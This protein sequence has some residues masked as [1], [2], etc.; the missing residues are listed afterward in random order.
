MR[1]LE[2]ILNAAGDGS[3]LTPG[4][5]RVIDPV[6]STA[7]RGYRNADHIH[8]SLFPPVDTSIRGG[9]RI[10]FGREDFRLLDTRRAP[11]A[12]YQEVQLGHVG[13]EFAVQTHGLMGKLPIEIE[14]DAMRV[15]GIDMGMR[16]VDG[17]Q[18][19]ISLR[20]E[21][22]AAQLATDSDNYNATHVLTLAGASQWSHKDSDP[23]ANIRKAINTTRQAIG[24][25]PKHVAL[26][27]SVFEALQAHK[28]ILK[29]VFGD[30]PQGQITPS[31]LAKLWNVDVVAVGDA[32]YLDDAGATAD[33]W[34]DNVVVH[35]AAV[36]P[37]TR[38]E[39]SWGLGYEID[40][41]VSVDMA[42]YDASCRSWK[43]PVNAEYADLIVGK[44][45]GY[46][47]KDVLA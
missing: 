9:T 45:A 35:Y 14:Q 42:W 5:A 13:K 7:A 6:L 17:T 44:D 19:V 21:Y 32:V 2:L 41:G 39:P 23:S 28:A 20:R 26:G 16:T 15:P 11:G 18:G 30:G 38:A 25:R 47:I 43:Y 8:Y 10:E 4:Q 40:G 31:N 29:A 33:I 1:D 3:Q 12:K 46:L 22:L 34:G 27:G 36:G 24:R 37:V